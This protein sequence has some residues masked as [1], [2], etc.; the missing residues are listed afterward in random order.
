MSLDTR[1]SAKNF[2]EIIGGTVL[3]GEISLLASLSENSL[4]RAH[5]KYGRGI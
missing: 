4:A 5:E 2:A 1:S 3:A